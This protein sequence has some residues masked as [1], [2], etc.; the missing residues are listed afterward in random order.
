MEECLHLGTPPSN[1]EC[2]EWQSKIFHVHDF[3]GLEHT[4][5]DN[6]WIESPEFKCFGHN[7]RL[8]VYPGGTDEA[9]E[10]FMTV[11]LYNLT[12][13][14]ITL[15]WRVTILDVHG[16]EVN[17]WT[18]CKENDELEEDGVGMYSSWSCDLL[19]RDTLMLSP[20]YFLN[21]G[22]LLI[23]VQ[24]R[25][26]EGCYNGILNRRH[27]PNGN[28]MDIYGDDVTSDVA[29]HLKEEIMVAHKGI[30]KS[31]AEQFYVMC[32]GYSKSSPMMIADVDSKIF[33]IMLRSLYGDEVCPEKWIQH[34]E[35]I[36]K[37]A[38]KYGFSTLESEAEVWYI[39]TLKFTVDNVISKFMEADG[40]NHTLVKAAAKKFMMEH[41][42][43][44]VDSDSFESL[45]ESLE[46]M[47][48]VMKAA[49]QSRKRKRE[50]EQ[51]SCSD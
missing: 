9:E 24:M 30:I 51:E 32:E 38:S 23:K 27:L 29:F 36:L 46:L 42:E 6:D 3:L 41:G 33:D 11:S 49:F 47:R 5:G 45:H 48:E 26:R 1:Y 19:V 34:S 2:R 40:S 16:N 12:K 13:V 35:A 8:E 37:A 44:I 14:K 28:Y 10:G 43:E 7:W 22:A 25:P 20:S 50:D 18:Y 4:H 17:Q 21:N 15:D 31:K 39:K